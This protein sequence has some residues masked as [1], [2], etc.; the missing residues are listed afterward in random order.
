M[1]QV[2]LT[3]VSLPKGV[4]TVNPRE[5][6]AYS[7]GGTPISARYST[8]TTGWA[9]GVSRPALGSA[10]VSVAAARMPAV[11]WSKVLRSS[12]TSEL[13][14]ADLLCLCVLWAL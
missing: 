3:I 4:A 6:A 11:V 14:N 1:A 2:S 7:S 12:Q 9:S 5:G 8:P 13:V 10:R